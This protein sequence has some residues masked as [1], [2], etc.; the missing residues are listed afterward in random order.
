[1]RSPL[2]FPHDFQ[3]L[4]NLF[5]LLTRENPACSQPMLIDI[6]LDILSER[7]YH[8]FFD[9]KEVETPELFDAQTFRIKV[10]RK[11]L[12]FFHIEFQRHSIR[13]VVDTQ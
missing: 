6:V 8:V 4:R 3:V 11:K 5:L 9:S 13:Q 1:V 10:S 7:G 2:F 12:Y